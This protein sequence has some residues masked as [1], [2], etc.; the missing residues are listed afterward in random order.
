MAVTL[1][2]QYGDTST[3][4]L[5]SGSDN[6]DYVLVVGADYVDRYGKTG[7]TSYRFALRSQGLGGLTAGHIIGVSYVEGGGASGGGTWGTI[8]GTLADQVD[9]Q[10]ALNTIEGGLTDGD[11]GDIT[12]SGVGTVMTIDNDAVTY[13][14]IQNVSATDVVL[15]RATSGA[16][17]IEEIACTAA[18]RALLDDADAAT[19]LATL[20]AAADSHTHSGLAPTGGSTGQVLKKNSATNYDYGWAADADSGGTLVDGD[21]GDITVSGSGSTWTIDDGAVTYAKIQNVSTTNRLLGRSTA[22]AGS[23]EEIACT[24]AARDLLDD[25]DAATMRTTLGLAIGTNVQAYDAELAALAST[26]SAANKLP[27]YTGSGTAT[28]TDFTAAGR[29]LLD[30]ADAAT[31]RATLGLT[32]VT[33]N[34]NEFLVGVTGGDP[35]A[36]SVAQ[37]Q[38]ILGITGSD[39]EIT[40]IAGL[41]SAADTLPY[42]TGSGTA[43]LAAFTAAGRALVDDADASAQRTTLGLAIGTNVQ[44]YDAE[45]AALAGLTSAADKVPYFTGSG[46]AA[47][48]DF[49]AAGRAL[50]DDADAAAQ[51]TTLGLDKGALFL[52]DAAPVDGTITWAGRMPIACTVNS[53]TWDASSG[54]TTV[55]VKINGTNITGLSSVAVSSS[56]PTTTNATAANTVAVGD[57]ITVTY[58][59]T[60]SAVNVE[61]S[62]NVTKG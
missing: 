42:F 16:G 55:A 40:A 32:G 30:D 8:T 39:A 6:C 22:G 4:T 36:K 52:F 7:D 59:S 31:Q 10:N 38:T 61:L 60:S 47:V 57:R 2:D 58:S 50:V 37:V 62:L 29:A 48:A 9:L 34:D 33:L 43:A 20:G 41:T 25:A 46:T 13:A 45:L 49:T 21:K 51:R 11:K 26:T 27:Y 3:P 14:K 53:L 15:G 54:S 17:I 35:V 12:I 44:A 1:T 19:M 56:G 24:S 28:T 18:A 23:V 5:T